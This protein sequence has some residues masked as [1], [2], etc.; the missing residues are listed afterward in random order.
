MSFNLDHQDL[1][2]RIGFNS[3]VAR[4][5]ES[6]ASTA[7]TLARVVEHS[8]ASSLIHT[9]V[10]S[11]GARTMPGLAR[12]A[13]IVVGDWV[14][15]VSGSDGE[16]WICDL[17]TPYT[18]FHR[19]D[20][21]GNRQALVSNVDS[22]FLVMGLDGDF[23]VRRLERY[24][25]L[26]K[27]AG[28]LAVVVLT[29]ADLCTDVDMFLDSLAERLPPNVERHAVN[30][31]D[32]VAVG[33]LAAHLGPG[34]T[35]VL[36]GS[37]GAGKSTLTNTLTR[38][39]SQQ[40]GAVRTSDSRGRHTTTSRQLCQLPWGGCLIDTPGLRGLRLDIDIDMLALNAA[41]DDI[42]ALAQDCRFRDC[43]HHNEPGCAVRA[44][45]TADRVANYHKLRREISRDRVDPLAR[46]TA[47]AE[48]KVRQ[49]ALRAMQKQRGR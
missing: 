10:E 42:A 9:G 46:Q 43:T 48:I 27:S 17:L 5:Q 13:T 49:R 25:A 21:S 32:P 24:I 11:H 20:P 45:V 34:Q 8:R 23:N 37:S 33:C 2:R 7:G 22:A 29:K 14:I 16:W 30:A 35:A 15:A 19:I 36:L 26:T 31:T 18:Q 12:S 38:S 39:F 44:G 1:L 28:A 3:L 4:A 41:F 40:T 47:K 6:L